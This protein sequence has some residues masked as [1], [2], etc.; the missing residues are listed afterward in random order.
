MVT[1]QEKFDQ[2]YSKDIKLIRFYSSEKLTDNKLNLHNFTQLRFLCIT[3]LSQLKHLEIKNCPELE[4]VE[5]PFCEVKVDNAPKLKSIKN[6][7]DNGKS[8]VI[9]QSEKKGID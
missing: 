6:N 8:T 7:G 9:V 4:V 3:N 2:E 5:C 1:I